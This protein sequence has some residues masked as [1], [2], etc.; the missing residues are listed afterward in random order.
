[1]TRFTSRL[2]TGVRL[3]ALAGVFALMAASPATAANCLHAWLWWPW[4]FNTSIYDC[5]GTSPAPECSVL[6]EAAA[7]C[8]TS[9]EWNV[10]GECVDAVCLAN[11]PVFTAI[12]VNTIGLVLGAM[13]VLSPLWGAVIHN[14]T[15]VAVVGNSTRLFMHRMLDR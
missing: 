4:A 14:A 15:T 11:E 9:S 5:D 7:C 1:M 8:A 3:G 6:V 2:K 13:G 12:G 10:M